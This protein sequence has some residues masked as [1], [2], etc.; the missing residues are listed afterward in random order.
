[1]DYKDYYAALGVA[2][3]ASQEEIQKAYRKLARKVH[4]DVNQTPEAEEKFK[5]IGEAYE[6]LKDPEKRAKYDRFGSAWKAAQSGGGR[7]PH[8]FEG[9]EGFDFGD[10]G[11]F[12]GFRAGGGGTGASGFSSFFESLFGRS[13]AGGPAA[14]AGGGAWG[15]WAQGG[16]DQEASIS[17][18]LEEAAGGGKRQISLADPETGQRRSM[19]VNIPAGVKPGGRIRL[20]GRGGGREGGPRGDLYLR[21]ELLPHPRFQLEG[22]DIRTH[23]EVTPWEAALGAQVSLDTLSGRVTVRIPPGSSSGR[24]V[25]LRG[26]GFPRPSGDGKGDLLAEIRIVVPTELTEKQR[27]LYEELASAEEQKRT[28]TSTN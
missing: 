2:R 8:G 24:V 1:M 26:Q 19:T 17:L 20:R 5:E 28:W 7:P 3:D 10:L 14:G 25:R 23:L 12:G 4:P 18:T 6:V 11:G 13:A 27:R 9:F 22:Q 21:I 16:T 15:P